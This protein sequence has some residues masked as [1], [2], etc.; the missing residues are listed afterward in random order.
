MLKSIADTRKLTK[1]GHEYKDKIVI[2]YVVDTGEVTPL[3]VAYICTYALWN[4]LFLRM[5]DV[6]Y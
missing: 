1:E 4:G 2:Y 3:C 5:P 6:I